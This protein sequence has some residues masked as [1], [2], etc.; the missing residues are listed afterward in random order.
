[1]PKLHC[2]AVDSIE[3]GKVTG[4]NSWGSSEPKP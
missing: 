1:M 4:F 2:V 3:N